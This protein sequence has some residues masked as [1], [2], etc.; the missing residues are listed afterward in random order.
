M[1][2][3]VVRRKRADD[4]CLATRRDEVTPMHPAPVTIRGDY[5]APDESGG[6][7]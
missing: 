3:T 1:P 2:S 5:P 4:G 6:G 7:D